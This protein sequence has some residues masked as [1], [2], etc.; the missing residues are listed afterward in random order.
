MVIDV[1]TEKEWRKSGKKISGATWED[2]DE[3]EL[4]TAKYPKDKTIVLYCS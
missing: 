3:W 1:R 2:A 4:W